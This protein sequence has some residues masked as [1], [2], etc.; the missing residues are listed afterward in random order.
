MKNDNC[1]KNCRDRHIGCHSECE[2][3]LT[4]RKEFE[5]RKR[6]FKRVVSRVND[7]YYHR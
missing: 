3:Y 1:C 4:W 2:K 6:K 7:G 5:E